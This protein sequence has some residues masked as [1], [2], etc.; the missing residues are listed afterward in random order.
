MSKHI[1][2]IIDLGTQNHRFWDPKSWSL[3]RNGVNKFGDVPNLRFLRI[4]PKMGTPLEPVSSV[5]LGLIFST[6][7][8]PPF[9][10]FLGKTG[11]QNGTK[12]GSLF[13]TV[14]LAQV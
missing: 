4:S 11:P 9:F 7:L 12:T 13:E 10:R 3:V 5:F 8:E 1:T 6:F 14:D 2:K